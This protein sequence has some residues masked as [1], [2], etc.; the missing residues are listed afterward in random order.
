[1][2]FD[3][4]EASFFGIFMQ[5]L[6]IFLF[7]IACLLTTQT[8]RAVASTED[9]LKAKLTGTWLIEIASEGV[10]VIGT[11]SYSSDGTVEY[12]LRQ[13]GASQDIA[14]WTSRYTIKERCIEDVVIATSDEEFS[15][16]GEKD[17]ECVTDL[18]LDSR[19]MQLQS[20]EGER[21]WVIKINDE[22][23]DDRCLQPVKP[24][25]CKRNFFLLS[26]AT[27]ELKDEQILATSTFEFKIHGKLWAGL[28]RDAR[29]DSDV[30]LVML[31][32]GTNVLMIMTGGEKATLGQVFEGQLAAVS[33]VAPEFA[34]N[35]VKTRSIRLAS[36]QKA[37]IR[38]TCGKLP[39]QVHICVLAGGHAST[40][41]SITGTYL[42]GEPSLI[43]MI[44][45]IRL[46]TK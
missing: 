33:R 13:A 22:A 20:A 2:N 24:P 7:L 12:R 35:P 45:S 31:V 44:K 23:G 3:K 8:V 4:I 16:V 21:H 6:L 39:T 28:Q 27:I 29:A 38:H 37:K 42:E 30:R 15:A 10:K 9:F 40:G 26:P 41:L 46:L 1:M 32:D 11:S 17:R 5:K 34:K 18:Q 19:R 25:I 43:E 36:G 14:S